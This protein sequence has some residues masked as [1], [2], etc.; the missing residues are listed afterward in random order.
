MQTIFYTTECLVSRRENVV[1]LNEYR[2][3]LAR[4]GEDSRAPRVW[5]PSLPRDTPEPACP[6]FRRSGVH[7]RQGLLLD[8]VASIG[9]LAM[10]LTFTLRILSL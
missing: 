10:T 4:V 9:V 2:R 1:D 5:E 3:K 8:L 7:R 6:R